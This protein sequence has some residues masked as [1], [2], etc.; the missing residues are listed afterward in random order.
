ML[1][2]WHQEEVLDAKPCA[3]FVRGVFFC[4]FCWHFQSKASW[5]MKRISVEQW[6]SS[7]MCHLFFSKVRSSDFLRLSGHT[8][9]LTVCKREVGESCPLFAS[10][11]AAFSAW[12]FV[13]SMRE[14]SPPVGDK[15]VPDLT[16]CLF[17]Y[18]LLC[19]SM[20]STK[21]AQWFSKPEFYPSDSFRTSS[22]FS[23]SF[24]LTS[25]SICPAGFLSTG[26]QSAKGNYGLLDQIQALRWLHENIGHFGGDHQR[27][28]IFGSGAGATCVN[29][30]ILSHHSEGKVP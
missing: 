29:L 26:D 11:S 12:V 14:D 16:R 1:C 25:A 30:L 21:A 22:V 3:V 20:S 24:S 9:F 5:L 6:N 23:I 15:G 18:T 4:L 10:H 2:R 19:L 28:T 17:F 7:L 27:I 13:Q 8:C